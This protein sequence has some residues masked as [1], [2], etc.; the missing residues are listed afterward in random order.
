L[1][2]R[3]RRLLAQASRLTGDRDL[4]RSRTRYDNQRRRVLDLVANEGT[5]AE[6]EE[7]TRIL[8]RQA[9]VADSANPR[10]L[11]IARRELA[12]FAHTIHVRLPGYH[13]HVFYWLTNQRARMTN[14]AEARRL[15]A[16]GEEIV[17]SGDYMKLRP[18]N[19]GLFALL[20]DE[21]REEM[22]RRRCAPFSEPL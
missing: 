6:R 1:D 17:A 12:E 11:E 10:R 5:A 21:A 22:K 18:I 19:D 8:E 16:Q 7:L 13:C 4:A 9:G 15:L 20:P 3:K 14:A 2:D